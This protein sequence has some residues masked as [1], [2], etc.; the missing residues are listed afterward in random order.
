MENIFLYNLR[1]LNRVYRHIVTTYSSELIYLDLK[2]YYLYK[3]NM[4]STH[5]TVLKLL[6]NR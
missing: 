2:H 5:A 4:D 1:S 3:Q 6:I